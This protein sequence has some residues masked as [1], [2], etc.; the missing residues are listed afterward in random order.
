MHDKSK[1]DVTVTITTAEN[2]IVC[3]VCYGEGMNHEDKQYIYPNI[4]KAA[5]NLPA[6]FSVAEAESP[7]ETEE[8]M[9][10]KKESINKG[11]Y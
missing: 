4:K 6:I 11:K 10:K 7:A 5:K 2:G 8:N 9:E 3:T 1:Q